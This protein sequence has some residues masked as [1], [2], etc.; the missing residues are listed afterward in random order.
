[1]KYLLLVSFLWVLAFLA[2]GQRRESDSIV[3]R[4]D[5][6]ENIEGNS[7]SVL[8]APAVVDTPEGKVIQF[9]GVD[10]ALVFDQ[11]PLAGAKAFTLEVVFRPDAGGNP[12][13]RF[14]HL[15]EVEDHRVLVETRLTPEG[16]WFL[17]TFLKSGESE[18][19]LYAED[20]LHPVGD[21]FHAALVYENG[22]MRHYVNGTRE[23][24][25][26]VQFLP[27]SGG[28]TSVGSRLNRV[29]WFKGAV[30]AIAATPRVLA[31][32]DFVLR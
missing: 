31:P 15:Q 8:G 10:D 16:K 6:L 12:E 1:M 4:L 25:G 28:K 7:P 19:T 3:W 2:C 23:L 21:W 22:L 14:V 26:E 9:D 5:N 27:M 29:Y 17:D 20:F 30:R 13:Q 18:C 32:A 11:N 24:E